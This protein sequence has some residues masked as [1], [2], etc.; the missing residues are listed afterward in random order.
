MAELFAD[1]LPPGVFN[2]VCGDR[3]TGADAGQP[4][5]PRDGLDHRQHRRPARRSR[6]PPPTPSSAPTSS[7]AARRRWSC[8][9]TPTSRRAAEGIAVAGYFNAGQDCT[10][11]TRVLAARARARRL[12]R[13]ARRA[14][15]G[16]QA[17]AATRAD[18]DAFYIPPVNN[19]NQLGHV[20]GLVERAPAHAKVV[21]GGERVDGARLLLLADRHRRPARRTTS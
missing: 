7:W 6:G 2:V 13:R 10:A 8:S 21:T 14:G 19:A 12:R 4:P 11:A 17:V 18:D 20:S 5:D 1:I 3:D 16:R 9:T 15:A